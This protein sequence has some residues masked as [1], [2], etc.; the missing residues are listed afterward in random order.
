V[1]TVISGTVDVNVDGREYSLKPFD[2]IHLPAGT[3]HA[4]RNRHRTAVAVALWAFASP[5]PTRTFA[6]EPP[7][8]EHRI[9]PAPEDPE[10]LVRFVQALDYEVA[11]GV[12]F[13]DLSN[14]T[15]IRG[16]YCCVQPGASLPCHAFSH[17]SAM[18]IVEGQAHCVVE[19]RRY[20]LCNQD[21][22]F[23]PHGKSHQFHNDGD[24]PAVMLWVYSV[25]D[26][27]LRSDV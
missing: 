2:A 18:T 24:V 16:G 9:A 1:I 4:V 3:V 17:D 12:L 6:F 21:T 7:V 5:E 8:S 14:A 20:A 15:Q 10:T 26:T 19:E 23:L 13:R 22:V 25:S 27:G 11:P